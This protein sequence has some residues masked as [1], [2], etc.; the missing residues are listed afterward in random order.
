ME[1]ITSYIFGKSG[2][3][4]YRKLQRSSSLPGPGS[5]YNEN[6]HKLSESF[7][8]NLMNSASIIIGHEKRFLNRYKDKT[9]SPGEYE[10]SGLI[11]KN[12]MLCNS[13]YI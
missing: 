3:R 11:I 1:G 13:K 7:S 4:K 9:S 6:N 10:I 5:Y 12:G 2:L 8:S